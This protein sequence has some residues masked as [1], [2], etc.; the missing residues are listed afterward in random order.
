MWPLCPNILRPTLFLS[1]FGSLFVI[2]LM[3]NLS[4]SLAFTK[5]KAV[6]W[7]PQ[8]ANLH[9]ISNMISMEAHDHSGWRVCAVQPS[10]FPL[11]CKDKISLRGQLN[12]LIFCYNGQWQRLQC[13]MEPWCPQQ[14]DKLHCL[15]GSGELHYF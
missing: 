6:I 11:V 10:V 7:H 5:C 15:Q 14:Q 1:S 2:T 8:T 4:L 13:H 12:V 3:G 9:C